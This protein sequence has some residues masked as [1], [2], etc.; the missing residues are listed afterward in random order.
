MWLFGRNTDLVGLFVPVWL[1]WGILFLLPTEYLKVEIELW[2]WVVA[3]LVIDVAH[4][5]TTLFRT[6]LDKTERKRYERVLTLAP[7]L[8]FLLLYGVAT[9]SVTWFWRGMAYVALFHFIRQQYGFF[10]LYTSKIKA[11]GVKRWL[12]DKWVLYGT[13]IYPVVYW[14]CNSRP[15]DWF[16]DNDFF[17][18]H[19]FSSDVWL[20][21]HVIYWL[22][23]LGWLLEEMYCIRVG[24]IKFSW[25]RILWLLTTAVNW[26]LGIVYFSSD[27]AFT[28]TN[29]VAHGIPYML[30]VVMYQVS[31][32]RNNSKKYSRKMKW[33]VFIVLGALLLAVGEEW[34]W[35]IYYNNEKPELFLTMTSYP[36]IDEKYQA[37]IL[38]IL[39]LPQVVHYVLDGF[40]WKFKTNDDL[41]SLFTGNG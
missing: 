37:L 39:S 19:L 38:A 8:I 3:V 12:N 17:S 41:K 2:V 14:H 36:I 6:Y 4:V 31:K 24:R 27:L 34:L 1:V 33:V 7:I 16:V 35:D 9:I 23:I 13:M 26:F 20:V 5:W 15:F 30:L 10:A 32:E 11:F 21:L 29:V 18:L 28:L 40:I 25:G 22:L